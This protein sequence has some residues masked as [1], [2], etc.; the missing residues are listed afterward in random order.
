[1][2]YTQWLVIGLSQDQ[3]LHGLYGCLHGYSCL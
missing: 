2:A 3:T 1:M